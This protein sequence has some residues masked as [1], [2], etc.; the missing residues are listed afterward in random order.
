MMFHASNKTL[1]DPDD[2]WRKCGLCIPP[3]Y[4]YV[5]SIHFLDYS[6]RQE[7]EAFCLKKLAKTNLRDNIGITLM[8][9]T[10]G[11]VSIGLHLQIRSP[12]E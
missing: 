3:E 1:P 11:N 8:A 7:G 12:V 2:D 6:K 9:M 10:T 4:S 5:H